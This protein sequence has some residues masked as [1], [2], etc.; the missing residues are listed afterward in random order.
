MCLSLD[1][2]WLVT[3]STDKSARL[4][5][6][7]SGREIRVFAGHVGKVTAVA[8]SG[9]NKWLVTSSWDKTARLWDVGTGKQIHVFEGHAD[10][11]TCLALS[12]DGKWL[13]TGS[14]DK[15]ASLWEVATG[16]Q[17]RIYEGH[18]EELSS[19]ALSANG[20]WL[21]AA[22]QEIARLWEVATGKKIQTFDS[23]FQ[24]QVAMS[25]DAKWLIMAGSRDSKIWETREGGA[26]KYVRRG[27]LQHLNHKGTCMALS[28]D[29]KMLVTGGGDQTA[30]L[31]NVA[32]KEEIHVFR[33][34]F[35]VNAVA[36]SADAR[37]LVTS[38]GD[39]IQ[40]WDIATRKE[41]REY[42]GRSRESERMAFCVDGKRLAIGDN[43]SF[44]N[45][46]PTTRLWNLT[47]WDLASGRQVITVPGMGTLSPDGKHMAVADDRS[48]SLWD[49]ASG[50]KEYTFRGHT[51]A[52]LDLAF[53]ADGKWFVTASKDGTARMWDTATGAGVHVFRGHRGSVASIVIAPNGKQLVTT[54]WPF[55]KSLSSCPLGGD[56]R[57]EVCM[58]RLS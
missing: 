34:S 30:R 37:R 45:N 22:D 50:R 15:T 57:G 48:I 10:F 40:L 32:T 7:D 35:S 38:C 13:V 33:H 21:L 20:K 43:F 11:V 58:F 19:L 36:F 47:L 18:V 52:V 16:K 51:D 9:D 53:S 8:I 39:S 42:R 17:V 12:A 5:E 3:G 2:K 55:Y 31:W 29:R 25:A 49:L 56:G 26:D 1:G 24:L 14:R 41:I 46:G 44:V 27:T 54:R 6:V 23:S 4:W 28:P